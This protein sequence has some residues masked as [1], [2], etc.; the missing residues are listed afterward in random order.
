MMC[1]YTFELSFKI[2]CVSSPTAVP[3]MATST[4]EG[5]IVVW[6]I[7]DELQV[8]MYSVCSVGHRIV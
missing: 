2:S 1:F 3:L 6:D 7:R 4:A 5:Q 8:Y